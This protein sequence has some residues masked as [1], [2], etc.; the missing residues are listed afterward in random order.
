MVLR[1]GDG[2]PDVLVVDHDLKFTSKLFRDFTRGL[3]SSLL[4]GSAYHENTN[5]KTKRVN[6]VLGDTLRTLAHDHKDDWDSWLPY[7][8]FAIN[9]SASTLSDEKTP[10]FIDHSSHPRLPFS[11]ADLRNSGEADYA[12]RMKDWTAVESTLSSKSATRHCFTAVG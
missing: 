12:S 3:S 6:G 2:V 1:S 5:T 10:F 11:L 7:A 9:K 4:V 8:V